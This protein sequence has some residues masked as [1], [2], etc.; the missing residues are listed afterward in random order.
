[1]LISGFKLRGNPTMST[2]LTLTAV[3]GAL[4]GKEFMFDSPRCCIAGR[5]PG[6][7]LQLPA[8]DR[9]VS[10]CHCL[11]EVGEQ[12]VWVQDIGSLNGTYL[13]GGL[14][15]RRSRGPGD[16]VPPPAN[17]PYLLAAGDEL[18]VGSTACHVGIRTDASRK[19]GPDGAAEYRAKKPGPGDARCTPDGWP[20]G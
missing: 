11:L 15:G 3:A 17:L 10:R 6:A 8:D 18:L 5:S 16:Q 4:K 14:I 2:H 12:T 9:S 13:N 7:S 19:E 20:T 1:M